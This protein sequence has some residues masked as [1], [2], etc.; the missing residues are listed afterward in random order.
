MTK[1]KDKFLYR[2]EADKLSVCS[3]IDSLQLSGTSKWI[4]EYE[5]KLASFFKCKYAV[6]VSSG[7]SA[8]HC[9]LYA[10]N[11]KEGDEVIVPATAPMMTALP[12][13]ELKANPIFVDTNLNNFGYDIQDLRKK[14]T[15]RTKA[16]IC[17]PMWG[18]P[19]EYDEIKEISKEKNIVL[20]EDAA[21]AHGSIINNKFVGTCSDIGCFSTHDKKLLSTGEGG[22]ILT[23]I[24]EYHEK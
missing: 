15:D 17:V 21:Q 24:K 3:A 11:V 8:I 19:F 4:E 23:D 22:F 12:I 10:S 9:A 6:A 7:T 13:L 20:I 16:I 2:D 14:V 5:K 1:I 18:Y